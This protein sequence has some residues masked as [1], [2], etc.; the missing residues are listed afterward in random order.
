LQQRKEDL[1][2]QEIKAAKRGFIDTPKLEIAIKYLKRCLDTRR[3]WQ[4][5]VRDVSQEKHQREEHPREEHPREEHPREEHPREV[6]LNNP[7]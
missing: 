7:P 3:R 4:S 6:I 1:G 2:D 5:P